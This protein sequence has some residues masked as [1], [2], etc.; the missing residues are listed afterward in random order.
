MER[1]WLTMIEVV[2]MEVMISDEGPHMKV[3]GSTNSARCRSHGGP[4][5]GEGGV[6]A[7]TAAR[8]LLLEVPCARLDEPQPAPWVQA[9]WGG[10]ALES[11]GPGA[12]AVHVATCNCRGCDL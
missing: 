2:T 1:G 3:G 12:L 6:G 9:W 10:V 4:R 5:G 7:V 8:G 11:C